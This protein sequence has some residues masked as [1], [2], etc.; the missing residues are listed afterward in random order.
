MPTSIFIRHRLRH[1]LARIVRETRE[2][3]G[4]TQGELAARAGVSR[5]LIASVETARVNVSVD[6]ASAILDALGVRYEL[7]GS[8]AFLADRRRQREPAHSHCSAYTARRLESEGWRIAREVE[9]VHGS[10]HGWIDVVAFDPASGVVLVIEIKSELEDLGRIERTLGWYERS[11]WAPARRM[12]WRPRSVASVLLV[13]A[14]DANERRLQ[15]NRGVLESAFPVRAPALLAGLRD[16]AQLP[17]G[18]AL[19]LIDLAAAGTTGSC[20]G[21]STA[22]GDTRRTPTTRTS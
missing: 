10:S 17:H 9:I 19:A 3:I 6:A 1:S 15:E 7:V 12:G 11:A 18:R 4:W 8:A 20:A 16:A 14:T 13:L 21:G 2:A 5:G 22:A